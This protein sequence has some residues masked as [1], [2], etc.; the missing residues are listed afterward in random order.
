[1]GAV[2][3][4]GV[5]ANG[6]TVNRVLSAIAAPEFAKS[7]VFTPLIYSEDMPANAGTKVKSFRR[8]A[9]TTL[10]EVGSS[11]LAEATALGLGA[12]R[13]DSSVDAT[14]AKAVVIQALSFE[15]QRFGTQS[16][17]S[18]TKS[19]ARAIARAVDNQ[20]LALFSS[21]T[22]LVTA[23][24]DLLLDDL[25]AAALLI[26]QGET[27]DSGMMLNFVGS[28][29]TA[30]MLKKDVREAGGAAMSNERFLS[31]FNGPAQA[32][33]FYGSLPGINLYSTSGLA[34]TGGNDIQCLFH[35]MWAFA[36]VFDTD[37]SVLTTEVGSGG[38][39]SEL[40]SYFFWAQILWCAPAACE[41]QSDT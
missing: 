11:G 39:Y 23:T 22:N 12:P 32:N 24:G 29:K 38:L 2:S 35:P 33:G 8:E 19:Q 34:T 41:V 37:I 4:V 10:I 26:R 6:Y 7:A 17:E 16:K 18:I 40:V 27:P 25:D 30:R 1:M 14:L 31:I 36:G 9:G 5:L 20:G 21:V 3:N 28:H 13:E 15:S